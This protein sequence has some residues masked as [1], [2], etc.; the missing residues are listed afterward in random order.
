MIHDI[1]SYHS[2]KW[3]IISKNAEK[4]FE[5]LKS[6]SED[7]SLKYETIVANI[8]FNGKKLNRFFLMIRNKVRIRF[9][10]FLFNILQKVLARA[11]KQENETKKNTDY[12]ERN[13]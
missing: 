5:E 3:I 8:K 1:K 12:R 9:F 4:S 2:N 11:T 13:L 10:P 6:I 7:Y